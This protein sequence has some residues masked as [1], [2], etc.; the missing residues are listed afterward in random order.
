MMKN[1]M[2]WG[3]MEDRGWERQGKKYLFL[4]KYFVIIIVINIIIEKLKNQTI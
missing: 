2:S 1:E 4:L 3:W